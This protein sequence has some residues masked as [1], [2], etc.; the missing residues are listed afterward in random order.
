MKFRFINVSALFTALR[1]GVFGL[2]AALNASAA[3]PLAFYVNYS[4]TV[5]T[6]PLL[7]HETSI[8]HPDAKVD[9]D[10]AHRAG[11]TVLAY[12]SIG[13]IASDAPYRG[14]VLKRGL[15]F[16]G[17]NETWKSDLIDLADARWR[18]FLVDELA[19]QIAKK[20]Y[21]GFFLDTAD[22]V[23]LIAPGNTARTTSARA[24]LVTLVKQLRTS[25]P[26]KR[27]VIN[28]GFFA[29]DELRDTVDG[30]LVE[31]LFETHD[32]TVKNYRA[33][34]TPETEALLAELKRVADAGRSVYVLDYADPAKPERADHAADRI[35]ALGYHAFVSTPTLDGK[36]LAPLRVVPR[37]ICA[38]FGNLTEV[39]VDQIRW[40][41]ESF[42][43]QRLQAPLEW[44]GYEVDY[45]RILTATDL[46]TLSDDYRGVILPRAWEIPSSIEPAVVDWLIAQREA[47][48]KI[49][50]F[51]TLPFNDPEQRLRFTTAFNLVGDGSIIGP[52]F[53]VDVITKDAAVMDYEAPV[54]GLPANFLRLR[55]PEGAEKILSV[56]AR[57]KQPE[58]QP[59]TFDPIFTCEWGGMAMDPY[60]FFR[61]ADYRDF[62]HL[63]PFE[64]LERALGK[65]D[66]PAPDTTTRDGLR[67]Y[68]SHIDGDGF[69]SFS[70]TEAGRRSAEVV[71]DRILKKYPLPVTVSVIEAEMRGLV[72]HQQPNESA[73]LEAIARDIL[74][75][76]HIEVASHSFSHPFFWITGD[77][78]ESFYDEQNLELKQKYDNLD[79]TRE[80]DGSVRYI[81]EKLAPPDRPV[82]VFLW[83]GNC[84]PPPEALALTRRLGIENL[85]GGDTIITARNRTLTAISPRTMP[86]GDEL[87]I[88]A[89]NQNENVYT[90]NWRGP[91]FGTYVHVIDTF[92][93]TESPRR[94]KPVNV[95]YHF[96]SGDYPAAVQALETIHDWVMT[97]PLHSVTVSHYARM[98]RD[99]RDTAIFAAGQD[100]W[101]ITSRGES[102]TFRLPENAASRIDLARSEGVTGWSVYQNETYVHTDG[103][104][105]VILAL[106]DR[107]G[108]Q[109]Y[110][111]TSSGEINFTERTPAKLAFSV[112]DTRPITTVLAGFPASSSVRVTVDG[113]TK[114]LTADATGR[115]KLSLPLQANVI[116]EAAP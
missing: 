19:T 45:H 25:F 65:T 73:E 35:R 33:V 36:M 28:R 78:T 96:Y 71:R 10:A 84:R 89:P 116:V 27:I 6:A 81:N 68:M 60:L 77:R 64:F 75:L 93:L 76:P 91:L 31:S 59:V 98:A 48:K 43:A 30:V 100:R 92:K 88:F 111:E 23:D 57:F 114:P 55:A 38:F 86:W 85:N 109:P 66:A 14:E 15:P 80:I 104:P 46:P 5:P 21:D 44:L 49:I 101:L 62:W 22:S 67:M 40:P 41:A 56:R 7:A 50:I 4:A 47:G 18:E 70:H 11:N 103:S 106:S 69:G 108:R 3:E 72:L 26:Q 12:L 115:V 90:N 39:Q 20:G 13:E 99:A 87:Q 1:F 2:V 17:R 74:R 37:R 82:K 8:V 54:T 53:Q 113:E 9:L 105:R 112:S 29:F 32:F 110:L 97:Q 107:P 24:G 94:M 51:G 102:R 61:R 34:A 42:V 16:A 79:L 63:N 52:P 58:K 83:S 95:Y